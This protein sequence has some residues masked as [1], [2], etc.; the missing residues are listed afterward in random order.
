MATQAISR[1]AA[2]LRGAAGANATQGVYAYATRARWATVRIETPGGCYEGRLYVP[3][4]KKRVSE[5][6]NDDRQFVN[7]A[8]VTFNKGE[9][10]EFVAINKSFIQTLRV[11]KE[12]DADVVSIGSLRS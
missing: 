5:V 1:T 7:L 8:N 10:E 3:D 2:G 6:L 9:A 4:G 11:L 12:G